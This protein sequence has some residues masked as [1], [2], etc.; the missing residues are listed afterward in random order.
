FRRQHQYEDPPLSW[1][2][3]WAHVWVLR[4][5]ILAFA[6]VVLVATFGVVMLARAIA[7]DA[8]APPSVATSARHVP[9]ATLVQTA[10]PS[11]SQPATPVEPREDTRF[12]D[13]WQRFQKTAAAAGKL[14]ADDD[15]KRR[16]QSVAVAGEAAHAA[17][18][19]DRLR[20]AQSEL[21]ALVEHLEEQYV[22]TIVS[23]P[24]GQSGIDRYE[25]GRLSGYYVIVEAVAADGG[26]L[27]RRVRNAETQRVDMVTKWGEQV[28]DAVWNRIVADEKADGVVDERTFAEKVRGVFAETIRIEDAAGKP[29]RRGRQITQW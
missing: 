10:P 20:R 18:D 9:P 16:V 17:E 23:R 24:G 22:V 6:F 5:G 15:A 8:P 3:F 7:D 19:Y 2:R 4:N 25:G 28:T 14:A 21:T 13:A 29:M 12:A 1:A 26:V 11:P 27:P